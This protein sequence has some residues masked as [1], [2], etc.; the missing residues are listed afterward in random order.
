MNQEQL[1]RFSSFQLKYFPKF[2]PPFLVSG[3]AEKKKLVE[4]RLKELQDYRKWAVFFTKCKQCHNGLV[5]E[6]RSTDH[7]KKAGSV[8]YMSQQKQI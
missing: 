8:L 6:N 7:Y 1:E 4:Y 3:I 2:I 5:Q